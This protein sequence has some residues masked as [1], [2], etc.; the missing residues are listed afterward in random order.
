MRT[1]WTVTCNYF[2]TGEGHTLLAWIGYADSDFEAK[3]H[4]E[5]KFGDYFAKG[6]EASQ[7]V[8]S[9]EATRFLFSDA[10]L[11]QAQDMANKAMIELSA[12]YHLNAS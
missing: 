9:D 8:R 5:K 12:R 11:Q 7:G 3:Q 4:F 6:A 1:L 2:A 10:I